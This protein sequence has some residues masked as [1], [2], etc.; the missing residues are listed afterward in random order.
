MV[1]THPHSRFTIKSLE[2]IR[3]SREITLQ[4]EKT[5][6]TFTGSGKTV[7]LC[8][9][10]DSILYNKSTTTERLTDEIVR[11]NDDNRRLRNRIQRMEKE[12]AKIKLAGGAI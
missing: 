9:V 7:Y 2:E 1:K 11:V 5:D 12:F 3:D 4:I 10:V 6:S 8:E